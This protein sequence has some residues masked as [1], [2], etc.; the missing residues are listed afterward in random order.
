MIPI[1][2][3][4]VQCKK[5]K[6]GVGGRPHS[7][8]GLQC[9]TPVVEWSSLSIQNYQ[10][11]VCEEVLYPVRRVQSSEFLVQLKLTSEIIDSSVHIDI[12]K[13]F[14]CSFLQY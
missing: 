4:G 6:R 10:V 9:S 13:Q 1:A 5:I 12:E 11:S 7:H 8:A 14:K 3:I 2:I